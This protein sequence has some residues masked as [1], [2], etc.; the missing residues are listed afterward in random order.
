MDGG[1]WWAAIH[2]VAKSQTRLSRFTFT[3]HFHAL[4]KG[5]ATHSSVL[6]WRIPGASEP[7]GLPSMG[8]HRVGHDWSDLAAAAAAV[9]LLRV[10]GSIFFQSYSWTSENV[11]YFLTLCFSVCEKKVIATK[12]N[13]VPWTEPW[14]RKIIGGKTGEIQIKYGFS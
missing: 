9:F 13:V 5:M 10:Q 6:A 7:G 4:E 8:L 11:T 1:A 2:E 3:F 14:N 12:C